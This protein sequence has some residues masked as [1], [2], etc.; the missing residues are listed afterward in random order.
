MVYCS[1]CGAKNEDQARVCIQCGERLYGCRF[2]RTK[3]EEEM[4][5]GLPSYWGGI[6][7]G[8]IVVLSGLTLLLRQV[9]GITLETWPFIAIFIGVLIIAG[10]IMASLRRREPAKS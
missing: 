10:A 1:N 2:E 6:I 5:F 4:C 8:V 3:R 9:Y 7:I